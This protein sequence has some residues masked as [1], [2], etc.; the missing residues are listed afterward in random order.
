[1]IPVRSAF[2]DFVIAPTTAT[3]ASVSRRATGSKRIGSGTYS[4]LAEKRAACL[5]CRGHPLTNAIHDYHVQLDAE[6]ARL[7]A[8]VVFSDTQVLLIS[9][10]GAKKLD[11]GICVNDW[12]VRE[13]YLVLKSNPP[14]GTPLNKCDIDWSRT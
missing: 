14:R 8:G 1:M 5:A 6:I 7:L 2:M 9:D 13:G 3:K 10:H 12:L 4:R 11:G